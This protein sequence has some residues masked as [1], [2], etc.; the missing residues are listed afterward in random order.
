M[1]KN[2]QDL[3]I[4][5]KKFKVDNFGKKS[6]VAFLDVSSKSKDVKFMP[7]KSDAKLMRPDVICSTICAQELVGQIEPIDRPK[8]KISFYMSNGFCLDRLSDNINEMSSKYLKPNHA[9]IGDEDFIVQQNQS[10]DRFTPPLFVLNALTNAAQSFSSQY[11]EFKGDNTTLG[12]TSQSSYYALSEACQDLKRDTAMA[13]VGSSNGAG[14]YSGISNQSRVS[15]DLFESEGSSFLLLETGLNIKGRGS[16]PLAKITAIHDS[17]LIPSLN[18]KKQLVVG[19]DFLLKNKISDT[20]VFSGCYSQ[21]DHALVESKLK[22]IWSQTNSTFPVWG[23]SG[24][25]NNF[26]DICLAIEIMQKKNLKTIDCYNRDIF[27][28]ESLVSLEAI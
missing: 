22:Q 24:V 2:S 25:A 8:E 23:N 3:G 6:T 15:N 5:T 1:L 19:C 20:C 21:E 11:G 13:V 7:K 9:Q 10:L 4:T 26:I 14:V 16:N 18:S 12:G 17:K 28:R 27:G